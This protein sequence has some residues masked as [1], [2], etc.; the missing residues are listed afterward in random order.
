[1]VILTIYDECFYGFILRLGRGG[2]D[3]K[4]Y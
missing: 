4:E 3:R 2:V 1:M